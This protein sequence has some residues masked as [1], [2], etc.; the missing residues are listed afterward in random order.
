MQTPNEDEFIS[1]VDGLYTCDSR[2]NS[3]EGRSH[4]ELEWLRGTNK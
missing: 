3:A 4:N 1:C 2:A